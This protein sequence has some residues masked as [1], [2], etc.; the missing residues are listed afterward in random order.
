MMALFSILAV[1]M[2]VSVASNQGNT[3]AASGYNVPKN[4][5]NTLCQQTHGPGW[6]GIPQGKYGTFFNNCICKDASYLYRQDDFYR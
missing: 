1:V 3:G 5:C 4:E 6:I 2:L